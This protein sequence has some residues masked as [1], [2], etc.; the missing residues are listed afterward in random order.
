[1]T[2]LKKKEVAYQLF[3]IILSSGKGN[4]RIVPPLM[5]DA[6]LVLSQ[7]TNTVSVIQIPDLTE[8]DRLLLA[9][10]TELVPATREM[11]FIPKT[12]YPKQPYSCSQGHLAPLLSPDLN[13]IS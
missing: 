12:A 2:C 1:M 13:A 9:D 8:F 11:R 7:G 3:L 6:V 4:H 10:G 5:Q